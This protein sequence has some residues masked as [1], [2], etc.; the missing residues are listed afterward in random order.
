M[1]QK[2][3]EQD[4]IT[5]VCRKEFPVLNGDFSVDTKVAGATLLVAEWLQ[6]FVVALRDDLE[7]TLIAGAVLKGYPD[8]HSGFALTRLSASS[9]VHASAS[10]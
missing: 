10:T 5:R 8:R 3:A 7:T 6:T 4:G 2:C 1:L 9:C